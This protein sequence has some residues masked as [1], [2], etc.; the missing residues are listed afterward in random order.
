MKALAAIVLGISIYL[1]SL[2]LAHRFGLLIAVAALA[3][4][5]VLLQWVP[6]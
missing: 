3:A 4:A 5:A 6:L 2:W 1:V